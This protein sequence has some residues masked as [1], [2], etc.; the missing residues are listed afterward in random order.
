M[1]KICIKSTLNYENECYEISMTLTIEKIPVGMTPFEEISIQ[2]RPHELLSIWLPILYIIVWRLL[3]FRWDKYVYVINLTYLLY[4]TIR[5]LI[6]KCWPNSFF[7]IMHVYQIIE[8]FFESDFIKKNT[9]GETL[10]IKQHI[11]V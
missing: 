7:L 4:S 11:F 6:W 5:L 3:N 1:R 2:T 8:E 9:E 10:V